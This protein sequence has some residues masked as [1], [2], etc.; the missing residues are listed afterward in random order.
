MHPGVELHA[1]THQMHARVQM[2]RGVCGVRVRVRVPAK[3]VGGDFEGDGVGY[4]DQVGT[5]GGDCEVGAEIN[6][7]AEGCDPERTRWC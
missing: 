4:R 7:V 1:N 3:G 6:D 2:H 5:W